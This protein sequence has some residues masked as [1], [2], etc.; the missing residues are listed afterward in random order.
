MIVLLIFAL[1]TDAK[2]LDA[3]AEKPI[4]AAIIRCPLG[5]VKRQGGNIVHSTATYA[6][7]MV[8][9]G[10]ISIKTRLAATN[11]QFLDFPRSGQ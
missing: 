10:D 1:G 2:Q 9:L 7:N 6:P 11:V 8:M 4:P 5:K 3:V